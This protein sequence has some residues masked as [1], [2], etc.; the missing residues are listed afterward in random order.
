MPDDIDTNSEHYIDIEYEGND[1]IERQIIRIDSIT[2]TP[3]DT[4][5]NIEE[6]HIA[7]RCYWCWSLNHRRLSYN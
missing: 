5:L 6:T 1:L 2:Q 7:K 3:L 4:M